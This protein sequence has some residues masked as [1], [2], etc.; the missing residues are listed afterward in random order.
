MLQ[1]RFDPLMVSVLTF[2]YSENNA[3]CPQSYMWFVEERNYVELTRPWYAKRLP[4]PSNYTVPGQMQRRAEAD[5]RAQF[6]EYDEV[7]T[8]ETALLKEAQKCLTLLS[9]KLGDQEF[10]FGRQPTSFDAI[11]FSYLAPMLKVPFPSFNHIQTHLK[12]CDNL[13]SFISRILQKYF[14]TN[15]NGT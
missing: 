4:F 11:V 6:S 12:A 2:L 3:I 9:E 13:T 5:H 7:S 10:F 8:Q 1:A 14:P 15:R